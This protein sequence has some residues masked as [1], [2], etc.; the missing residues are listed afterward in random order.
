MKKVTKLMM[1]SMTAGL[2]LAACGDGE[3][4][5]EEF[6]GVDDPAVEDPQVP[7]E[8]MEDGEVDD[9]AVDDELDNDAGDDVDG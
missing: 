3:D 7:E 1:L 8:E 9:S 6:P 2:L 4:M 5:N